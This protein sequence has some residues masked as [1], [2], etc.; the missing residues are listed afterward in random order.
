MCMFAFD[1]NMDV[2]VES[3]SGYAYSLDVIDFKWPCKV[4]TSM[5]DSF[6]SNIE[7]EF[8]FCLT[9]LFTHDAIEG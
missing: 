1:E 4:D 6:W 5:I 9:F 8:F 3:S 7:N 2:I